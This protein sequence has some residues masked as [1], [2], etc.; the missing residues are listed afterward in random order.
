MLVAET[1]LITAVR[2]RLRTA[3]VL[4]DDQCNIELDDQIPAIAKDTYVA[5]CAAGTSP[6]ERHSSSGG[7]WDLRFNVRVTVYQRTADQARDRRRN[8]FIDRLTG[9]NA[10][11][12]QVIRSVDFDYTHILAGAAALL[13]G[14]PAEG[15]NYPEPFRSFA[16]DTNVRP[17][18]VDPYDAAAMPGKGA[19]PLVGL[20]RGVTFQRARFMKER[21]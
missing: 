9:L 3:L 7:V 17:V 1:C 10:M 18:Y 14:T 19:D 21:A 12:D 11:V 2:D 6:G 16:I 15:G 8:L 4:T 13:V 20:S 5:V